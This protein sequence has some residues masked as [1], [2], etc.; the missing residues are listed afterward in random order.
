[1][2]GGVS[3]VC[4][5]NA[6]G[7][8]YTQITSWK[9]G[10]PNAQ[11]PVWSPNG[12][13]IAVSREP[14]GGVSA[15]WVMNADGSNQ[16]QVMEGRDPSWSP[17]GARIAFIRSDGTASQIFD[18]EPQRSERA[19]T[20][21]RGCRHMYPTW[22]PDGRQIAFE[23]DRA[24][25]AVMDA[26]GGRQ[27]VVAKQPTWNLSWSPDGEMLAIAPSRGGILLVNVDG[28]GSTQ[29]TAVGTQP[30]WQPARR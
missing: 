22:S 30:A 8:G 17:D 14:M 2:A 5:V 28:S 29:I 7:S 18:G 3:N 15:I 10:E 19:A 12:R 16:T 26:G 24:M 21:Q 6:D 20:D 4:T 25:V 13:Q 1:M 11:R 9:Q 23:Y 27:Q